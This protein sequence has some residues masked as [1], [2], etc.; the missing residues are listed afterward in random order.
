MTVSKAYLRQMRTDQEYRRRKAEIE[1]LGAPDLL[2]FLE[3][4]R[5]FSDP[6]DPFQLFQA[7]LEESIRQYVLKLGLCDACLAK[8]PDRLAETATLRPDPRGASPVR[9]KQP[10]G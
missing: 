7:Q 8:L 3:I 5:R 4:E 10:R 1:E 2:R 6:E 9:M